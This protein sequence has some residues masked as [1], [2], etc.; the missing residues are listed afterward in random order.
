MAERKKLKIPQ[1]FIEKYG[2]PKT[3]WSYSRLNTLHNCLY[4]YYLARIKRCESIDNIYSMCGSYAH[5]ILE[6]FYNNKIQFEKM[7]DKF[8]Q[9]FLDVEIS[10]FKFSNDENRNE[11]MRKKYVECIIHFFKNHKIVPYKVLTEQEVWIDVKGNLF[12]GYIDAIHKEGNDYIITDYK[13][14]SINEYKGK[15]LKEKQKQLL[16]YALGLHQLGI[17]LENIKIRWNFLK[18]TNISYKLKN[19][20]TKICEGERNKWINK[21]KSPLRKDLIATGLQDF[22]ADLLINDCMI[23]N[24]LN[25]INE[26]IRNKYQ[27]DDCY[28]YGEVNEESINELINGLI[29]DIDTIKKKGKEEKEWLIDGITKDKEYYCNV[30]CGV[31]KHCKF[32]SNF[33]TTLNKNNEEEINL[34]SQLENL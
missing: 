1:R 30:L 25:K 14:S 23:D 7:A 27:L 33:L 16:L 6:N 19:G 32:Y 15:K 8:E 17:P 10:D 3:I 9:D 5:D 18:Y 12:I 13:T 31:R 11:K 4:E 20:K 26:N 28:V 22:E 21:I 24:N 34:L 29:H 2:Q